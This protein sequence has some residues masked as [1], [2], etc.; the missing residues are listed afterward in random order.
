MINTGG[1]YSQS[2]IYARVIYNTQGADRVCRQN[3]KKKNWLLILRDPGITTC[4]GDWL[5]EWHRSA[6]E[7]SQV[8][9]I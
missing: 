9:L 2:Q 4:M 1:N 7:I 8:I 5:H 6:L 3:S